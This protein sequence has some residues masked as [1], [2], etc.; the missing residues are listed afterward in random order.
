ML[1]SLEWL[2]QYVDINENIEELEKALTMIGQEVEAIDVQG[3]DLDNVVIGH[4]VEYGR[5][6]E[7]DKLSL[8]KVNVGEEEPLQI[9]CGAPNHKLGDKVVVAKIGAVLP[10]DFKIKKSK[11]RGIE[12]CG[13]CCS[14]AELGLGKDHSGIIILPEDAPIGMEYR[15]YVGLNDVVFELE[16][17]PN[18]P[19]CLS[20][21]GIARE[22]A[23]YYGREVKYPKIEKLNDVTFTDDSIEIS[24]EDRER[25][26]RFAGRVIR[27]VK[28]AESPEWLKK[29]IIAMGLNPINNIV[30]IS[31]F[32]MF[33]YNQPI[34][35]YDLKE[36]A[37]GKVIARRG[38]EGEKLV[39]LME[40]EIDVNGELVIAD[41]EKPSGLAGIMGGL[42][43]GIKEDTQDIFIEVAY[44]T[45]EDIRKAGRKFGIVS[46][47]GYRNERGTDMEN[48]PTVLDR[49]TDLVLQLANP[50][51]VG[52]MIDVY[53]EKYQ[54]TEIE[55]N[56][57]KLRRFAGKEIPKERIIEI[58]TNLNLKVEDNG[59][60]LKV[61]PPSYRG[62]L[63]RPADLYEEVIRMYGF[64][65]IEDKMPIEDITAGVKNEVIRLMDESKD[66]LA[67]IGL[68]EV[69]NYSFIPREVKD[70]LHI[71][72]EEIMILNPIVETMAMMRPTLIYSILNNIKENLNRNQD[73]IKIFEV[74]KVF[75]KT[76]DLL[77]KEDIHMAIGICGRDEKT[78]WNPK[79]EAYDFYVLKGYVEE[80]LQEIGIKGYKIVR[81]TNKNFHPG[82]AADIM[83]GKLVVGTFGEIHPEIS[84]KMD[85]LKE[86][87]YIAEMNV[88][89]L[90][91]Y[92]NK[93]IK[94]ERVVKYPEVTRDFAIVLDEN[95]LVGD[96]IEAIKKS[97]DFIESV[98][99]FDIYRGEH[100]EIGKKSVA[101][102]VVM[103]DKKG[104]LNEEEI[105]KVQDKILGIV[106]TKYLG[107][108]RQ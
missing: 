106:K 89:L 86:R 4:I 67:K 16:I 13:M 27:G 34:H 29:R 39:T 65:N 68:Q 35:I 97:S 96:M 1:I 100:I 101:I 43:S 36:I 11:I 40:Q 54:S 23:A 12:S 66:A 75:E 2:K 15:E 82:R 32:V 49:V 42:G 33:E 98:G 28:V 6:P 71:E 57:E 41:G 47:A 37:G 84:E 60:T 52:K 61:V 10:G 44:F 21:I 25:C 55:L 14:K 99:L 46:D 78:L 93:K 83:I 8:L 95:V 5:H 26:K 31:N 7:A 48:V 107:E 76:D 51:S 73:S 94:Y 81:T 30:D 102:S 9:V 3:K 64:E 20:H 104:T 59:E 38:K 103:R 22:I 56:I 77:A 105:N 79:P 88:S 74:A 92:M 18:R 72:K 69:I 70:M 53:P 108:I 45:P 62:D 19:D 90:K 63:Y 24:I 80:Y 91:Q 58:L 50:Q 87:A 85:I 17:T